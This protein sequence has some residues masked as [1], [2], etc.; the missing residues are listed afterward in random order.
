MRRSS[1][2]TRGF[3][4]RESNAFF[5]LIALVF[6][7][8]YALKTPAFEVPD[9]VAHYW[10]ATA[11]AYGHVVVGARVAL[12]R[13]YRV[14]V[15]ALTLTPDAPRV[16]PE[17]IR[18][19]K[20][21]MLQDEYRDATPVAGLYSPATYVPQIVAAAVARAAK[22]R[23]YFSFFAGRLATLVFCVAALVFI[24][25]GPFRAH[26]LAVALLPMS[27]FLFG[28][29]SADALTIVA[30]FL[31]T[32]LLL[33]RVDDTAVLAAVAWLS[34]CKPPYVLLALLVLA[35]PA[36]RKFKALVIAVMIAGTMAASAMTMTGMEMPNP[37]YRPIDT[38]AQFRFVAADPLHFLAVLAHDTRLNGRD[39]LESMTGRLGRYELKLPRWTTWMLWLLLLAVGVTCGP[40]LPLRARLL[41][42]A[43][44]IAVWLATLTYL[45][46]TSSIAG[47]DVIE[48]TQGRY[49]LP[50]LPALLATLRVRALCIPLPAVV[51][52]AVAIVA[53]VM[54]I[55]V[56]LAH[57]W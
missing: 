35:V 37:R 14:I 49:I 18:N 7:A 57:Y 54:G 1:S 6:G 28:S 33:Q 52:Y 26:F 17:R 13:G 42:W 3:I 31:V 44:A 53:N 20:G 51:I 2:K 39:Y 43:I 15:W 21:V 56:L 9:E 11:A 55:R 47:G 45:Y 25:R 27:L 36:Q 23:P 40:P 12:P 19:A 4:G 46:L 29:W 5:A 24:C 10:R 30:G 38:R 16:T 34:L 50:M 41:M 22:V 32:A 48:G 8:A